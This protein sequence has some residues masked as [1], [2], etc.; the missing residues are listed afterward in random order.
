MATPAVDPRIKLP[1]LPTRK[2]L[3]NAPAFPIDTAGM[4]ETL[5]R[6]GVRF[7]QRQQ[8]LEGLSKTYTISSKTTVRAT[9]CSAA[10]RWTPRR[11][12]RSST[13]AGC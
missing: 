12:R 11:R 3:E 10:S 5:V 6:L 8:A 1:Q 13:C 4:L 9:S 7:K 2:R